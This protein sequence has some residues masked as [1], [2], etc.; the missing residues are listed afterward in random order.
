MVKTPRVAFFSESFHEVNGV[1]RTSR[2]FFSYA[3]RNGLPFLAVIPG[4][5]PVEIVEGAAQRW[6]L[7][8]GALS[9]GIDADLRFDLGFPRLL[10]RLRSA[11]D[12][13]APDLVHITGPGHFGFLG[14]ILAHER[15][16]PLVASWHT[17]VH[18]F[19]A[20][21]LE[22][23]LSFLPK[24]LRE[25]A[26]GWTERRSLDATLRFYQIARLLFAPNPEL[27]SMLEQSTGRPCFLM[28]RGV[29]T[30]LFTPGR[31]TRSD[32][33]FVVGYVGRLSPEKNV[34]ALARLE[35]RL[36]E[37]GIAEYRFLIAGQG[38]EREWLAANLRRACLPGV[39]EGAA[40]AEAYANMDVFVF[41]SE[42]DT[43][44]NAVLEA[45]ASGT[46]AVVMGKGGPRFLVEQGESGFVA[47][48]D[49][50]LAEA[51]LKLYHS[52]ALLDRM[53]AGARK[54]AEGRS[55]DAV[56]GDVYRHYQAVLPEDA[57]QS[58]SSGK[59]RRPAYVGL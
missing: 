21:R 55:W 31:R 28:Q 48:S 9:F 52:P 3:Q 10:P 17:N 15:R 27:V 14:A 40:L 54:R 43:F 23:L 4:K 56:F 50:E 47:L 44:G 12:R 49:E 6:E 45:M 2:A 29:D 46:P 39:L 22:K 42:T 8:P 58:A 16:I 33:E 36:R 41:P 30:E 57:H 37:A 5:Q 26:S 13:F 7:P 34:R 51:V 18:E 11:L 19:G 35:E 53:R 1:A 59:L 20:R 32:R 38:S 24:A 25:A